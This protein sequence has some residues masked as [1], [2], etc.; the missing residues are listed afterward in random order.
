MYSVTNTLFFRMEEKAIYHC[1]ECPKKCHVCIYCSA[2]HIS[3]FVKHFAVYDGNEPQQVMLNFV[4]K[5][6]V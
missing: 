1:M 4:T 5:Y 2:T 3:D 6:G